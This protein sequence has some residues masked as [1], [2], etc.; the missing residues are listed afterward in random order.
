MP[1]IVNHYVGF[2]GLMDNLHEQRANIY[3]SRLLLLHKAITTQAPGRVLSVGCGTGIFEYEL[4]HE[5]GIHIDV[6]L[7]PSEDLAND[8]RAKGIK[9]QVTDAQRYEYREQSF[10]TILYNGS[11]FGFIPDTELEDTFRKN[12]QALRSGGRIVL[13]D[14]PAESPL[15]ILLSL[16]QRYPQI[17]REDYQPLLEGTAFYDLHP[18]K[19]NWHPIPFY[20]E[21]LHRIG[22]EN[23]DF[24]QTVLAN[25]PYQNDRVEEVQEGYERGNYIAIV[26][27]KP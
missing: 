13:T 3:R 25:P 12:Y 23:I 16:I 2:G 18:Y 14:V 6:A 1:E 15:G 10:D 27:V 19:P 7:E 5:F 8:A 17:A 21:V 20:V 4:E 24:F 22:F 9:V 26:A 11:S